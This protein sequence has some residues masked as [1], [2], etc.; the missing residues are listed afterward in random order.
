MTFQLAVA[1]SWNFAYPLDPP[2]IY[3]HFFFL[4]WCFES[5]VNKIPTASHSIISLIAKAH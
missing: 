4:L 1:P 3:I 2:I 5:I